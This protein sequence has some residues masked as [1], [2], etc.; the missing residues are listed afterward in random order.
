[1]AYF[2]PEKLRPDVPVTFVPS[3]QA[4]LYVVMKEIFIAIEIYI[5]STFE[6]I[7]FLYQNVV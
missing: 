5:S 7:V 6:S 3:Y 1:L 2:Y 4:I